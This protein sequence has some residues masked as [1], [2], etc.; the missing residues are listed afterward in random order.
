[1]FHQADRSECAPQRAG[2]VHA[3][4]ERLRDL[5]RRPALERMEERTLLS[6]AV[7]GVS[8][9][10]IEGQTLSGQVGNAVERIG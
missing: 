4:A 9:A 1:M 2:C 3:R 6:I 10:P 8:I 5:M 7:T